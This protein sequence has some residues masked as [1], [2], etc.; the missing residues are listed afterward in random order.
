M[1]EQTTTF[2]KLPAVAGLKQHFA[3]VTSGTHLRELLGQESR[4][5][6]LRVPLVTNGKEDCIFDFTHAKIDAEGF[7]KL[8][9][10]ADDSKLSEKI[11]SMFNGVKINNTEKRSV[12]H[13]ALRM[14]ETESLVVDETEGDVVKNVHGVLKR[15]NEFSKKIRLGEQR[16]YSGKLLKNTLAIG[17]GGSYLG[18]E[19]VFE[20]LKTD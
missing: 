3:S 15:I 6:H 7:E 4:N 12:L 1:V 2:D 9:K 10:V 8:L 18:P 11:S 20:A 16:G 5:T 13:V 14:N 17:I 19:F